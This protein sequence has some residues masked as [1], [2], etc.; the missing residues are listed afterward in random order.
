MFLYALSTTAFDKLIF[1]PAAVRNGDLWRLFTWPIANP[2]NQI[3]VIL[4]LLFFWF[5][6]NAVEELLGRIRFTIMIVTITVI[7]AAV[8][9]LLPPAHFPTSAEFGLGL[10]GGACL[11]VF[12]AEHPNAP[13]FFGVPAWVIT[14]V[15]IGIDVLWLVGDR[16]WGTF[17]LLLLTIGIA[18]V[19][20]RQWGFATHLTFIP[21]MLGGHNKRGTSGRPA[22]S[23]RSSTRHSNRDQPRRSG[24]TSG[25]V[26]EGPWS[27][28]TPPASRPD[29]VAAQAELDA[30][31]D[32]ISASGLDSL[33]AEEKR[34]LN[35]LS[36][37]LR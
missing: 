16:I 12:A 3:F 24:G 26:V 14:V 11:A 18:L 28:P 23:S 37:R 34:H 9:T 21:N 8:V 15:F 7:P 10:L 36:K 27:A 19:M 6:G 20:V 13:F 31:L 4:T 35:D 29:A 32:K 22:R 2:P 17:T 33:T 25:R 5:I 30:L 1:Y